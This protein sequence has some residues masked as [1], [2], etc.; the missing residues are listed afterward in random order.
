[1]PAGPGDPLDEPGWSLDSEDQAGTT[2]ATA[3]V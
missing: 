1:L 3:L 2:T